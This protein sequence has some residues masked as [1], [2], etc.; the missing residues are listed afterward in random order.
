VKGEFFGQRIGEFAYRL[1]VLPGARVYG[2][3]GVGDGRGG[4][5]G[6]EFRVDFV[7]DELRGHSV[8]DGRR[9]VDD[10]AVA[11]LFAGE[12]FAGVVRGSVAGDY[13]QAVGAVRQQLR[14]EAEEGFPDVLLE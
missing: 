7:V 2:V 12:G 5:G 1:D 9:C 10:E 3:F 8:D 13:F 11:G 14:V 4:V 6:G